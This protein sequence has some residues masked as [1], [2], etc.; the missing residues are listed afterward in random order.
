MLVGMFVFARWSFSAGDTKR[1]SQPL[2][3]GSLS[4]TDVSVVSQLDFF[5][6]KKNSFADF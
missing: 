4:Y 5:F 6:F 1:A 2:V 3:R